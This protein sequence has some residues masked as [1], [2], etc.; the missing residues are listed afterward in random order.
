M[1]RYFES[2]ATLAVDRGRRPCVGCTV[3]GDQRLA[4]ELL[5]VVGIVRPGRPQDAR[6]ATILI[7]ADLPGLERPCRWP[8]HEM[9]PRT[10]ILESSTLCR[11]DTRR[12]R[13]SIQGLHILD[14]RLKTSAN[15]R[16]KFELGRVAELTEGNSDVMPPGSHKSVTGFAVP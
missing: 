15:C 4:A 6:A 11:G 5:N 2:S 7:N 9:R 12:L 16:E 14:Y 8:R 1:T 10:R 3:G 13:R